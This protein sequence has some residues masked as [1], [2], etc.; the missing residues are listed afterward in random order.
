MVRY[1]AAEERA[2]LLSVNPRHKVD[3]HLGDLFPLK[4]TFQEVMTARPLP[5]IPQRYAVREV[6]TVDMP[7]VAMERDPSA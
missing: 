5:T 2:R 6:L 7:H 4:P 3:K 1:L